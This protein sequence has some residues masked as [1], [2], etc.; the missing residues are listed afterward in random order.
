[1]HQ[2]AHGS[3]R[4]KRITRGWPAARMCRWIYSGGTVYHHVALTYNTGGAGSITVVADNVLRRGYA[5]YGF[6][7]V[8]GLAGASFYHV[9]NRVYDAENGRWTKRDPLGYVD[10]PS[11]YEYCRGMAMEARDASGL[12]FHPCGLGGGL[13]AAGG[14]AYIGVQF[15]SGQKVTLRNAGCAAA[16]G[17]FAGCCIG[18]FPTQGCYYLAAGVLAEAL[19]NGEVDWCTVAMAFVACGVGSIPREGL[20]YQPLVM[21]FFGWNIAAVGDVCNAADG[22]GSI[23]PRPGGPIVPNNPPPPAG[24]SGSPNPPTPPGTSGP[25]VRP[26]SVDI[27]QVHPGS[28]RRRQWHCKQIVKVQSFCVRPTPSMVRLPAAANDK[29]FSFPRR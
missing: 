6:N 15:F 29:V 19:Y 9:R 16:A 10:G 5:G 13:S 28:E 26:R 4:A 12:V 22:W 20:D 24:G 14:L 21:F 25:E 17:A 3:P 1:M 11:M 2:A 23:I 27:H 18:F 7:P 8:L